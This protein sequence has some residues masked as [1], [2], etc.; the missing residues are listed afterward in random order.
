MEVACSG[1]TCPSYSIASL[2][3]CARAFAKWY[4]GSELLHEAVR[5]A[6][7]A[8]GMVIV[9]F[10]LTPQGISDENPERPNWS[11]LALHQD[12]ARDVNVMV[13]ECSYRE[14]S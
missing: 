3:A 12:R 14:V 1:I 4:F 8:T 11:R 5:T 9:L 2:I 6:C 7:L 13:R 10:I